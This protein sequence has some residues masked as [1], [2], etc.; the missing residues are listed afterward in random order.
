MRANFRSFVSG[1]RAS[2]ASDSERL[3]RKGKG[4]PGSTASG[5]TTGNTERRK[6]LRACFLVSASSALQSWIR[7][8]RPAS[9]GRRS[10]ASSVAAVSS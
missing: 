1:S 5:V 3:E 2:T 4:C 9:A 8:P 7:I 6:Y 10:S